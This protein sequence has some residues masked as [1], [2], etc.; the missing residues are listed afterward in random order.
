MNPKHFQ[1]II[2]AGLLV[3]ILSGCSA[4]FPAQA[5]PTP[6]SEA[7][8]NAARTEA[9]IIV[10]TQIASQASATPLPTVTLAPSAT[11]LP[12]ATLLQ[13]P[14]NT[15]V[16]PTATRPPIIYT[17]T[18][19][20]TATPTDYNCTLITGSPAFGQQM[21]ALTDF[22][23]VWTV[24]N[25]GTKAWDKDAIDSKYLGGEKMQKK[26]MYDLKASVN[27]GEQID[28]IVDMIAPEKAGTYRT[29]WGLALGSRIICAL[30]VTIV[31]K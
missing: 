11:P 20:F 2:V 17:A 19:A 1:S 29:D 8:L 27:P 4:L 30:S 31:V 23:A 13:I 10:A 12:T 25:T 16:P 15:A 9:A 18:P 22:D 6:N 28:V 26:D 14:T 5:Q 7:T 3:A 21:A 24:K